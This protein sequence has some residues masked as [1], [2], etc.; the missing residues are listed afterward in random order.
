MSKNEGKGW[1]NWGDHPLVVLVGMIAGTVAII[2]FFTGY[3]NIRDIINAFGEKSPPVSNPI[4][5]EDTPTSAASTSENNTNNIAGNWSG[6]VVDDG[7]N[8]K[9]EVD[10]QIIS[11]CTID[12]ICGKLFLP[13]LPCD[14]Y[15]KLLSIENN[16][17]TFEETNV[18]GDD[19]CVPGGKDTL[20]LL[21]NGTISRSFRSSDGL[22]SSQGILT[23]H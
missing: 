13:E 7:T 17:F 3:D 16:T 11:D 15:L 19:F 23:K 9:L 6:I 1:K 2:V 14:A 5:Q 21:S 22:L 18:S 4:T 8:N 10:I 20:E 12:E